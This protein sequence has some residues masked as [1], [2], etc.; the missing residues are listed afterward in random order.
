MQYF[1]VPK[2]PYCKKRVNFIR[3]W[4]LKRQG[5]YKC[6]RCQG[7]S[8]IYLSPLTHVFAA[9]AIFAAVIFYFFHKFILNDIKLSTV[10]EVFLPFA[11]FYFLSFFM[12]YLEKPV[13]KKKPGKKQRNTVPDAAQ[14]IQKRPKTRRKVETFNQ[15]AAFNEEP[16]VPNLINPPMTGPIYQGN[17]QKN[18]QQYPNADNR[19][20]ARKPRNPTAPT[21]ARHQ[22]DSESQQSKQLW[23]DARYVR[24][25]KPP[26]T[27]KSLEVSI[28]VTPPIAPRKPQDPQPHRQQTDSQRIVQKIEIGSDYFEKYENPEYVKKRLNEENNQ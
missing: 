9:I 25:Q 21:D 1:G 27:Q 18:Q 19:M 15:A 6:P 8:N 23:E 20:P 17:A 14:N 10:I 12:V 4:S 11:G 16:K 7:I 3:T 26:V 22:I 5:E 13:I 2:C 28:P 24:Q